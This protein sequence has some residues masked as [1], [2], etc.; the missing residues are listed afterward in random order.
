VSL[1]LKELINLFDAWAKAEIFLGVVVKI[2]TSSGRR[3]TSP[4][5]IASKSKSDRRL[6]S[7]VGVTV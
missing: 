1:D 3:Q 5:I 4:K 6:S 7:P 2:D